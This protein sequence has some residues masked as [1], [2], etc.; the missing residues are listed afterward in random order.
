VI[1]LYEGG[2]HTGN[3]LMRDAEVSQELRMRA[4]GH[5]DRSVNDRYTHVLIE[6]TWPPRS[7]PPRWSAM[8][9]GPRN[10]QLRTFC[11]RQAVACLSRRW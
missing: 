10:D 6:G 5:S 1:K 2:S 7:R 11:V 8:P 9:G 3:S 4:V